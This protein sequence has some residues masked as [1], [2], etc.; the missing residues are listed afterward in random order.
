MGFYI[1]LRFFCFN[2]SF[3]DDIV[4]GLKVIFR[5]LNNIIIYYRYLIFEVGKYVVYCRYFRKF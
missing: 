5:E 3:F 4:N 2:R 1:S